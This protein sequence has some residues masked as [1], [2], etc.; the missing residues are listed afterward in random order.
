MYSELFPSDPSAAAALVAL[1]V[2]DIIESDDSDRELLIAQF[3][4]AAW[5]SQRAQ[6]Q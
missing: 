2:D 5:P 6:N 1:V 4:R 3:L